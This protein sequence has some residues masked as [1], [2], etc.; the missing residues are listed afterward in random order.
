MLAEITFFFFRSQ[1]ATKII[2]HFMLTRANKMY[3]IYYEQE[4]IYSQKKYI[5]KISLKVLYLARDATVIPGVIILLLK[6]YE[7]ICPECFIF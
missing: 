5:S 6:A 3:F 1:L 2:V 7:I 4:R